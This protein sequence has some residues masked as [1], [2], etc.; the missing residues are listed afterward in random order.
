MDDGARLPL[1][2]LRGLDFNGLALATLSA[3][4]TAMAGGIGDDGRELARL[5]VIVH[6][7]GARAVVWSFRAS[8]VS[9][10]VVPRA[11]MRAFYAGLQA[12]GGS[13]GEALRKAQLR[14][15][16]THAWGHPHFWAPYVLTAQQAAARP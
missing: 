16:A 14:L 5:P 11:F 13:V 3:C 1:N 8:G 2:A 15:I 9:R 12:P 10:T 4:Q 6:Q 7:R